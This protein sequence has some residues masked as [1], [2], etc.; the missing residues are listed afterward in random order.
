MFVVKI[1][2]D[3]RDFYLNVAEFYSALFKEFK[4]ETLLMVKPMIEDAL[5]YRHQKAENQM[6]MQK[7]GLC[8]SLMT[9]IL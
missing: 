2:A 9:D 5:M 6:E 7:L 4:D 3:Y 8:V 1:V